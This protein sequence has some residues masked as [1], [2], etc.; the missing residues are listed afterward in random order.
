VVETEGQ[1]RAGDWTDAE[2]LRL[3]RLVERAHD[4]G[5]WLRLYT[6]NGA[7]DALSRERGWFAGYDFGSLD[8]AR[9]RWRACLE[10]GVDF[11]ATDQYEELA[12]LRVTAE[13]GAPVPGAAAR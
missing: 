5:L 12:A 10:A 1:R 8:A 9:R 6:L 4:A 11:V 2:A 3:A 7:G 13:P